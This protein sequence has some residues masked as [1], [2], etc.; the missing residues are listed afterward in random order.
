M[1][2]KPDKINPAVPDEGAEDGQGEDM[3]MAYSLFKCSNETGK[4]ELTEIA[5][6]PLKKEHLDT[7][8]TFLLETPRE[9]FVWVGKKANFE[10]KKSAMRF[11]KEFIEQKGKPK[12]T[13]ISRIPEFGE[14]VHFKSFFNGFYPCIKQDFRDFRNDMVATGEFDMGEMAKRENKAAKALFD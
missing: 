4:L 14:D 2:G 5:E 3:N 11:A 7:N 13:R 1:G 6:R 10:E 8:D 9:I 12:N